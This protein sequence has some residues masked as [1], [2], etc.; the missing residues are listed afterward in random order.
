MGNNSSKGG[1]NSGGESPAGAGTNFVAVG[2]TP[3][4]SNNLSISGK[5]AGSK[6]KGE[7]SS[8]KPV[9]PVKTTAAKTASIKSNSE[10]TPI[11]NSFQKKKVTDEDVAIEQ[12]AIDG[13]AFNV[14]AKSPS[15]K[16]APS[17][18]SKQ[19]SD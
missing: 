12:F 19:V 2:V 11:K 16:V 17:P 14:G 18:P 5:K 10:K 8:A 13:S 4:I 7:S 3:S 15:K 1:A 6:T 9:K